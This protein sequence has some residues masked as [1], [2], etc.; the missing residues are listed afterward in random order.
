MKPTEPL[1]GSTRIEFSDKYLTG[2][3]FAF[4]DHLF[5]TRSYSLHWKRVSIE[6]GESVRRLLV[7]T[8][9]VLVM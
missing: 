7:L 2:V 9:T 4:S 6:T 8:E 1:T 3:R 5:Q